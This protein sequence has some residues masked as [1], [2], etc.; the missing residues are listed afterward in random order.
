LFD[1]AAGVELGILAHE[2]LVPVVINGVGRDLPDEWGHDGPSVDTAGLAGVLVRVSRLADDRPEVA[3]L[4]L[5][6]VIARPDGVHAVGVR[7]RVAPAAPRDPGSKLHCAR[8][9]RLASRLV[10][11][12]RSSL[13]QREVASGDMARPEGAK[14]R[15]LLDTYFLC[16]L[17]SGTEPA[18]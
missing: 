18:A 4:D 10:S 7:V 14:L 11:V 3:E 5:N 17:A 8:P 13:L 1:Q 6:P 9:S 2:T 12:G 16:E 15:F